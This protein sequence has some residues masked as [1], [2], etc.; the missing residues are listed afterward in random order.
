MSDTLRTVTNAHRAGERPWVIKIGGRLCEEPA[1]RARLAAA[2]AACPAPVVVVHGGGTQISRLQEQ[3]GLVP[4]FH[5]GRRITGA[6]DLAVA[7][8]ALSGAV[9]K[10]LVRTLRLAGRPAVGVSGCDGNLVE[11]GLLPD[12]GL[13]GFP[14]LVRGALLDLLLEA[15][16]TPVVSPVSLGPD[17]QAVNVNADEVACAVATALGAERLL[18]LSDVSGVQVDGGGEA[19]AHVHAGGVVLDR[20]VDEA[21]QFGEGHD[22]VEQSFGLLPVQAEHRGVEIDVLAAGQVLMEAGAQF[23]QGADPAAHLDLARRGLDDASDKLEQ[24]ALAAAIAADDAHA[25]ARLDV[26]RHVAHGPQVL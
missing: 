6:A 17:G 1:L 2:V 11:C 5:E 21:A 16:W 8:M 12:L 14:T 20:H 10:E 22:L 3:L 23:E 19:Q 18:L 15:G 4:R 7:E 24:A 26:E 25:A 13:V 9:N